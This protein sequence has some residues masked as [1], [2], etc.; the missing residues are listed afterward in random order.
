MATEQSCATYS[1]Q[2]SLSKHKQMIT[3][4]LLN[5][6][7]DDDDDDDDSYYYCFVF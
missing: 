6:Y 3:R 2:S 5:R 7:D 4:K 1:A